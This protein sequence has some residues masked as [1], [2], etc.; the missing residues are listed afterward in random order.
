[1]SGR[2]K[3]RGRTE[4]DDDLIGGLLKD[5]IWLAD[6]KQSHSRQLQ[7]FQSGTSLHLHGVCICNGFSDPV[8]MS[9]NRSGKKCENRKF[10]TL[11]FNRG[12]RKTTGAFISLP[13]FSSIINKNIYPLE[14]KFIYPILMNQNEPKYF[15]YIS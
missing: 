5:T 3:V 14:K 7:A 13:K 2:E 9:Y 10:S 8:Q 6:E 15:K 12:K 1:M 4:A 11:K